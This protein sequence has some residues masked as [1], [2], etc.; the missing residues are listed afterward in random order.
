[1]PSTLYVHVPVEPLVKLNVA[2]PTAVRFT[3]DALN[4]LT[5]KAGPEIAAALTPSKLADWLGASRF[6]PPRGA[7][8]PEVAALTAVFGHDDGMKVLHE[9]IQYLVERAQGEQIFPAPLLFLDD[10]SLPP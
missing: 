5:L 9:T 3:C 10:Y 4:G 1:M 7:G 6:T 8:D 2:V